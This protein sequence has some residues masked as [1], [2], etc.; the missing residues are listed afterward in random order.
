MLVLTHLLDRAFQKRFC[1]YFTSLLKLAV[2][3]ASHLTNSTSLR[4]VPVGSGSSLGG[5]SV[6]H[7]LRKDPAQFVPDLVYTLTLTYSRNPK[8]KPQIPNPRPQTPTLTLSLALIITCGESWSDFP[9]IFLRVM[10]IVIARTI[11]LGWF[12]YRWGN[13]KNDCWVNRQATFFGKR[14][15]TTS[16][17]AP[18]AP[19]GIQLQFVEYNA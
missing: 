14:E 12:V 18:A 4:P 8:P 2:L 9:H 5:G 13:C 7:A 11:F 3:S 6:D 1:L 15:P 17:R 10:F 16:I 19:G